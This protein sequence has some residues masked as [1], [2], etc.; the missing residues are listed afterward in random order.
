MTTKTLDETI[1]TATD[2]RPSA[3]GED[4][5]CFPFDPSLWDGVTHEWRDKRFL[6]GDVRQVLHVPVG[7]GATITRM[8]KQIVDANA[9]PDPKEFLILAHDPS[10]W[11]SELSLTVTK[12]V[13]GGTMARISGTFF[14]KVFDGPYHDVP[15]WIKAT[16]ELLAA[17]GTRA[18]KY[19]FHYAYCPKC[20][21][22]YGHNYCVA[23]ARV[24]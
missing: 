16:D 18:M 7:M 10:P 20:A 1:T 9:M 6:R 4:V 13:P 12:D 5:C 21:K 22:K 23:F 24:R 15:K 19:Y 2:S 8:V 3:T 11:K 14:S 17:R